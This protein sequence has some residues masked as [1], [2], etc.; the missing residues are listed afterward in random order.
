MRAQRLSVLAVG[1]LAVL[2]AV[3]YTTASAQAATAKPAASGEPATELIIQGT[4]GDYIMGGFTGVAQPPAQTI[5]VS[6][7]QMGGQ[8]T[9]GSVHFSADNLPGGWGGIS[10]E[11]DAPV[12]SDL[13]T[14]TYTDAQS[15]DPS[16]AIMYIT[17]TGRSCDR[18]G[19]SFTID[20]IAFSGGTLTSLEAQFTQSCDGG[21]AST[22]V[23]RYNATGD[24]PPG[25]P[26]GRPLSAGTGTIEPMTFHRGNQIVSAAAGATDGQVM[27]NVPQGADIGIARTAWS[28]LGTRLFLD[29][30]G[31]ISSV[32]RDGSHPMAVTS[33]PGLA[34][35]GDDEEPAISAD[36]S[37]VVTW[38]PRFTTPDTGQLKAT[39]SDG[40]QGKYGTQLRLGAAATAAC[41]HGEHWPSLSPSGALI[42]ECDGAT[43]QTWR[44]THGD[45]TLLIDNSSE[46]V[47]SADG[48]KI[49]FLRADGHGVQQVFTANADGSGI[50]QVSQ[51]P[52]GA[53]K[54]AW[55][56]DGKYLAYV[57]TTF[58]EILEIP[59][60][61]GA[62]VGSIPNADDPDW[63]PPLIDSNV[64]RE[65][66]T[67][68][69]GT[70]VAASQLNFADH[71][72]ADPARSQAGAV[73]LARSDTF[74]DA[75]G[76][77]ALAVR[78]NAPLLITGSD[79]LNPAVKAEIARVLA[80]G[81]R[82]YLLGGTQALSPAVASALS[83]YTVVRLAGQTRYGTAVA[84]AKQISP[85][86]STVMIATGALFPDAL[87]AGATGEP[88]LLTNGAAM[89][90]ETADFLNTLNPDPAAAGGTELVTIGGPGDAALHAAYQGGQMPKWPSQISRLELA[91]ADRYSTALTVARAYFAGNADVALATADTWPDAL[92]GGA[93][94]GHR[95]GPL[96]LTA[97][98]GISPDLLSYLGSQSASLYDLFLLGGPAAL[99][100]AIAQQAA[101]VIG[102][103]GHVRIGGVFAAGGEAPAGAHAGA[104]AG[105]TSGAK[106][107]GGTG[108]PAHGGVLSSMSRQG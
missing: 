71:G 20:Q 24:L 98:T 69:I 48:S 61:G 37:V 67:D 58:Q 90:K 6:G 83:R 95:G 106:A 34:S 75:L 45:A 105:A 85:R 27:G 50:T 100:N 57:S 4:P 101:A 35:E 80:P 33:T 26:T 87:A 36:G 32:L 41:V 103:P 108:R 18:T 28:P 49:A 59:S 88:V 19:G 68:R 52:N 60:T 31:Q 107:G 11:L 82:I 74:A 81:G 23:I 104:E 21:P 72:A 78:A 76:G 86:P 10:G 93:M 42:F 84:I 65:G 56:P 66:G 9:R 79:G 73:V 2:G 92:S 89:P 54:P 64:V 16:A 29:A 40:S 15:S 99:P 14:G 17:A 55:S 8:V 102:M 1:A 43:G 53:A 77:S 30:T 70:A 47:Y 12:G 63:T 96:L 62:P 94:I 39:A 22:G 46:A 3:P 13:Q 44:L 38:S 91:G 25:A 97:P 5:T 7:A 51:D